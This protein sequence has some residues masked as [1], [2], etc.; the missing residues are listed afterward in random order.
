MVGKKRRGRSW[1]RRLGWPS[2]GTDGLGSH[3]V[4]VIRGYIHGLCMVADRYMCIYICRYI[5]IY[6]YIYIWSCWVLLVWLLEPTFQPSPHILNVMF[7]QLLIYIAT[8]YQHHPIPIWNPPDVNSQARRRLVQLSCVGWGSPG[9]TWFGGER[10]AQ[11]RDLLAARLTEFA[12]WNTTILKW[13]W[14]KTLSPW[15]TSK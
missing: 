12:N 15:W 13:G 3:A 9:A 5:Y 1:Q 11:A 14:V 10:E 2:M 7:Y 8:N 4:P 6:I